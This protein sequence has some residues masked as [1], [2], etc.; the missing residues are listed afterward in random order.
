MHS[1]SSHQNEMALSKKAY[2]S[3]INGLVGEL[4]AILRD[5]EEMQVN[6]KNIIEEIQVQYKSDLEARKI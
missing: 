3:E 4:K 1:E 5:R 6:H 2:D